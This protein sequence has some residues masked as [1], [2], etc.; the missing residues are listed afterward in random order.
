VAVKVGVGNGARMQI[1]EGL[2]A[3]DKIVLPS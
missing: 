1:L 2:K 3:G